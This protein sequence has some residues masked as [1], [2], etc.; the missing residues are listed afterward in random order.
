M[1]CF[2]SSGWISRV[3]FCGI[4]FSHF[5]LVCLHATVAGDQHWDPQFGWPGSGGNNYAIAA[6]NN[7]LYVGGLASTT[8]VALM[9]WDGAQW[10]PMSQFYGASGSTA[11]YDIAFVGDTLYAAG[12]FTN[13]NGTDINGLAKWDGTNWSSVGFKGVGYSLAVEGNNLYVGGSFKTNLAGLALTNVARWDGAN[14]SALGNGVGSTNLSLVYCVAV[15]NGLLYAGGFFTNAGTV[16]ATNVASWNGTSWSALST[17]LTMIPVGLAIKGTDLYAGG[18]GVSRWDGSAWS[19]VGSSFNSGVQN[20][21]VLGNLVCAAGAF[22][23]VGVSASHFAVWNGS[24]WTAAGTGVS[25]QANKMFSTGTNLYVAGSFALAGGIEVNGVAAWDGTTWSS[26]GTERRSNGLSSQVNAVASDGTNLYAGGLFSSAGGVPASYVARFDGTNWHALGTGIG[27][28]GGTTIINAIAV[29]NNHVYVGGYFSSAGGVFTLSVAHWDGTNWNAMGTLGGMVYALMI[30]PD[31][32]YAAG[33]G[34]NGSSYGSAFCS[35]WDGT[36][37]NAFPTYDSNDTFVQFYLN[38][39]VGMDAMAAIGSDI[40]IGGRFNITWHDPTLSFF[41]NCSNIMRCTGGYGRV[42]GTG[43]NSNVVA[44]A[45][46]QSDLYVSGPFSN[47]GGIAASGLARWDGSQWWS[48]GTGVNGRGTINAM[49]F[50]GTN[51]YAAGSFTNLGGVTVSRIAKWDGTTWSPLGSG[52][53]AT[54]LSLATRGSDLDAGGAL[55]IAGGK[56]SLFVGHWN[57]QT[58]FDVPQ[59]AHPQRLAGQQFSTR[60]FGVSGSTNVIEATTNFVS[61]TPIATNSSGVY[62]FTDPNSSSFTKRFYRGR[63]AY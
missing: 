16:F 45:V 3:I 1:N 39:T 14:W 24:T 4:I 20:L 61:W 55:R 28:A 26:I 36:N 43:L 10:S 48:V 7:R 29:T 47:A 15:T 60:V 53:S 51:L 9:Q 25:A 49:T 6:H 23:T 44:M 54:M 31:G 40:Y 13:I 2:K 52:V 32:V 41:T 57:D 50:M 18:S 42:V 63:L 58:N 56:P 5:S 33:T 62:D 21:C 22:T 30:R 19:T 46:R 8:N 12:S 17:G 38:D 11:I 27:P 34:Y 37:W 59:L 35:R